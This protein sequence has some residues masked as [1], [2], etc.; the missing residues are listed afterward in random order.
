MCAELPSYAAESQQVSR[1]QVMQLCSIAGAFAILP[2]SAVAAAKGT[3]PNYLI[4][5]SVL[6]QLT[7]TFLQGLLDSMLQRIHK[8]ATSLYIHLDGKRYQWMAQM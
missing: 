4:V 2:Q 8:I 3:S 6:S 1:R 5:A 7:V